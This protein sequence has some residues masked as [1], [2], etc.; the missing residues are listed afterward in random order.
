MRRRD[1]IKFVGGAAVGWPE[2]TRAQQADKPRLVGVLMGFASKDPE[3]QNRFAAFRDA[4]QARGWIEGRTARIEARWTGANYEHL[5]DYAAELVALA[6]DV[7]VCGPVAPVK[8]LSRLT[9]TIPIVF[10]GVSDP[11]GIG[12]ITDLAR[13]LGNV[14]GF[15]SFEPDMGSKWL[16]LLK[17]IAP[18]VLRVIVLFQPEIPAQVATFRNA[19]AAAASFGVEVSAAHIHDAKEIERAVRTAAS[20]AN[21][22]LIFLQGAPLSANRDLIIDLAARYRLPAIY[23][24]REFATLGGLIYY[25]YEQ[26][27]PWRGAAAYADRV[28]KGEKP[29]D[30]PVQAPTKFELVINLKTAKALGINVSMSML[31]RADEV[32]E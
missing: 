11:V 3:A 13:P 26:T 24:F 21:C 1:F 31:A 6:P 22:G 7:L 9:R 20:E 25:G 28:L 8:E 12:I 18:G 4:L 10:A 15:S 17:E 27:L 32:I 19:E 2:A 5:K 30:L 14:S 29:G 23:P 16:Q